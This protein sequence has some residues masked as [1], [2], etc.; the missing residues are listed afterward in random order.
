MGLLSPRLTTGT[1]QA[2]Q[3]RQDFYRYLNVA[4][5]PCSLIPTPPLALL[6]ES[7]LAR[8]P[9]SSVSISARP[10]RRRWRTKS[11]VCFVKKSAKCDF[12]LNLM[13]KSLNFRL[14]RSGQKR[15]CRLHTIAF[16]MSGRH[17]S[18]SPEHG[19]TLPKSPPQEVKIAR[20]CPATLDF[21]DV[22]GDF[23]DLFHV[24]RK[25][26]CPSDFY[27]RYLSMRPQKSKVAK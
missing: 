11:S 7:R 23:T 25:K 9:I 17:Y 16:S 13:K 24:F 18:A 4:A 3:R 15:W 10:P 26:P 21:A 14:L 5:L 8:P 12:F 1:R 27:F 20:F 22:S 2:W 6:S 19:L